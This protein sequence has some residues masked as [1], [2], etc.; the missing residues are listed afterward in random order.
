MGSRPGALRD[1]LI[2]A[3]ADPE[4]AAKV[5]EEL[6]GYENRPLRALRRSLRRSGVAPRLIADDGRDHRRHDDERPNLAGRLPI[7]QA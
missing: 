1:A 5:A 2:S 6:A 4:K 7:A 3:T